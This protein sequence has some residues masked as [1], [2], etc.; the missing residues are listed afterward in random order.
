MGWRRPALRAMPRPK[1]KQGGFYVASAVR[2]HRG[3]RA[4]H[5]G[6]QRARP[7][8]RC[9]AWRHRYRSRAVVGDH[10]SAAAHTVL[11]RRPHRRSPT[12]RAVP[13]RHPRG[14]L[15]VSA[16]VPAHPGRPHDPLGAMRAGPHRRLNPRR[17][18]GMGVSH[19]HGEGD[20]PADQRPA[21]EEVDDR[22]RPDVGDVALR[23]GDRRSEV[24]G[25]EAAQE[26]ESQDGSHPT[27]MGQG[28]AEC[29]PEPIPCA[30]F[31]AMWA[32]QTHPWWS[33][34]PVV[35]QV[36]ASS[37]Q[38]TPPSQGGDT[39]SNPVGATPSTAGQEG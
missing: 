19:R 1:G 32:L 23:G 16:A 12:A 29:P 20:R 36:E 21:E 31:R 37:P 5:L 22:D 33:H 10:Q 14:D 11:R 7:R 8:R 6:A 26:D 24:E 35:M 34:S 18:R 30:M 15:D 28:H 2:A 38:F 17:C 3:P 4:D 39:G 27:S 9:V 25:D 13:L